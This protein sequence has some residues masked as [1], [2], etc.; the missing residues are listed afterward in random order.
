MNMNVSS[1]GK[2][3]KRSRNFPIS[4]SP[5]AGIAR[6][7]FTSSF[8]KTVF[9]SKER[10]GTSRTMQTDPE[11]QQPVRQKVKLMHRQKA[12]QRPRQRNPKT[13]QK[14]QKKSLIDALRCRC[15]L[16]FSGSK[17]NIKNFKNRS[18]QIKMHDYYFGKYFSAA[19]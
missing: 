11:E 10:D 13:H 12:K 14:S 3:K 16:N 15:P 4:L 8:Q 7:N 5:S 19:Q 18:L 17:N 2:S 1:A 6:E 9:I